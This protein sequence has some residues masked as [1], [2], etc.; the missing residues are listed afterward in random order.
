MANTGGRTKSVRCRAITADGTQCTRRT[1]DPTG[2]CSIPSHRTQINGPVPKS[3]RKA[4]I[5][6]PLEDFRSTGEG[7]AAEMDRTPRPWEGVQALQDSAQ[8]DRPPL[9]KDA[10]NW[11]HPSVVAAAR[12]HA[13]VNSHLKG[14]TAAMDSVY[15]LVNKRI[16]A[17]KDGETVTDG[18][19]TE[20]TFRM[21]SGETATLET[22]RTPGRFSDKAMRE[23]LSSPEAAS[24][25][26]SADNPDGIPVE[27]YAVQVLDQ[28]ALPKDVV[29]QFR[30]QVGAYAVVQSSCMDAD[31]VVQEYKNTYDMGKLDNWPTGRLLEE[32]EAMRD[33]QRSFEQLKKDDTAY[34]KGTLPLGKYADS[35]DAGSVELKVSSR[36]RW[37]LDKDAVTE[38]YGGNPPMTWQYTKASVMDGDKRHGTKLYDGC[39]DSTAE[40][41][42][43]DITL[44]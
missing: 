9:D 37:E 18:G 42:W 20:H 24:V 34:L 29:K 7:L 21:S 28:K 13:M 23:Y 31:G 4:R 27:H 19:I 22:R 41:K 35:S 5:T 39:R 32:Y 11:E 17:G 25:I 3:K 15:G 43:S 12:R 14:I 26:R 38:Y 30:K 8:Y 10:A 6:S 36:A 16:D 2:F 44:D 33:I 40:E 1:K